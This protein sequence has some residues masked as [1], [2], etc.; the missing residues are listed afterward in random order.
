[1]RQ[2]AFQ[3]MSLMGFNHKATLATTCLFGQY[4]IGFQ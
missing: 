3:G 1:M 4:Y 2:C